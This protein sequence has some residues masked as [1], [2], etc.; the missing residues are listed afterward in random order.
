MKLKIFKMLI[1]IVLV[2][3]SL[4]LYPIA[5]LKLTDAEVTKSLLFNQYYVK[6]PSGKH[7]YEV[8][9]DYMKSKGWT[10]NK[11]KQMGGMHIFEKGNEGMSVSNMEIK[12]IIIDGKFNIEYFKGRIMN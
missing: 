8:F 10:E 4:F 5:M 7:E 3:A 9:T 2:S 1:I 11:E 12:T 6:V